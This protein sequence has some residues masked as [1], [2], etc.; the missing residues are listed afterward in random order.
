M[1]GETGRP[2]YLGRDERGAAYVPELWGGRGRRCAYF[3]T[4]AYLRL[5]SDHARSA[6]AARR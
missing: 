1:L 5:P 3:G 4:G 2:M 6:S